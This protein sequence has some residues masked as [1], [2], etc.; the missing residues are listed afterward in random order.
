MTKT[1]FKLPA[2]VRFREH[3]VYALTL[4]PDRVGLPK[5][6]S[7]RSED[8]ERMD[9][10]VREYVEYQYRPRKVR[11]STSE[12]KALGRTGGEDRWMVTVEMTTKGKQREFRIVRAAKER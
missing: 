2:R 1:S 12:P 4:S 7:M 5:P 9:E 3:R 10:L 6:P 11:R 8:H